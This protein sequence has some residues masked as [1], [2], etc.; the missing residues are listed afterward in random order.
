[1]R[2]LLLGRFLSY[3]EDAIN[4]IVHNLRASTS[5]VRIDLTTKE[6]ASR[7]ADRVEPLRLL[8]NTRREESDRRSCYKI[9]CEREADAKYACYR[10]TIRQ[11]ATRVVNDVFHSLH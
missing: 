7:C 8:W 9:K 6:R 11:V 10:S 3:S 5:L 1:M 4:S 2:S